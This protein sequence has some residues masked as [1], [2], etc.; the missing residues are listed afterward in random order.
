MV[1]HLLALLLPVLLAGCA[2]DPKTAAYTA[3]GADAATTAIGIAHGATELNPLGAVGAT[4]VKLP[5]LAYAD[6]QPEPLRTTIFT[7]AASFWGGAAV[8][9]VAGL[10]LG[11]VAG[12]AWWV[13]TAEQREFAAI[14]ASLRAERP[15][16]VC[17]YQ[18]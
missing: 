9:N 3:A 13:S 2:T 11:V 15:Q 1:R 8:A 7:T 12:A 16:L 14:C 5:L 4:L 6:K 18:Q 17:T 10:P